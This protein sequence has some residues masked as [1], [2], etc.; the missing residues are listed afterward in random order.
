MLNVS[1]F[2]GQ[3]PKYTEKYQYP[4]PNANCAEVEKLLFKIIAGIIHVKSLSKLDNSVYARSP[5]TFPNPL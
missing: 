5:L 1:Q 2:T 3:S 4:A